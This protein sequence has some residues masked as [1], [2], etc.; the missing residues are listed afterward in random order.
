MLTTPSAKKPGQ[1]PEDADNDHNNQNTACPGSCFEDIS[2]QFAAGE[3]KRQD[4]CHE[5]LH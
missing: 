4:E 3:R 2:Y 1:Q 5:G